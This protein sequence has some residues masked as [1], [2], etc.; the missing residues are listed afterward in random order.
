ML[1]IIIPEWLVWTVVALMSIKLILDLILF[2]MKMYA[3]KLLKRM[4][5]LSRIKS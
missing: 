5:E 4:G 3:N 1:T 2:S